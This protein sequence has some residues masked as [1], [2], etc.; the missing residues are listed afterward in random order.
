MIQKVQKINKNPYT[1]YTDNI[2]TT[3]QVALKT[4]LQS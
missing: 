3:V 1:T 4:A 2:I